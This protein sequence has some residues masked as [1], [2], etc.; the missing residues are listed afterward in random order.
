[1][2]N[3]CLKKKRRCFNSSCNIQLLKDSCLAAKPNDKVAAWP[4]KL[5]NSRTDLSLLASW[6][7]H[8]LCHAFKAHCVGTALQ[9]SLSAFAFPSLSC[10]LVR[11]YERAEKD[12]GSHNF[13]WTGELLRDLSQ[14][15]PA[16]ELLPLHRFCLG[17]PLSSLDCVWLSQ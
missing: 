2:I 8:C 11:G 10:H 15:L 13:P 9:G 16:T 5:V 4:A 1:M 12:L 17:S 14:P 3:A 6:P 7:F